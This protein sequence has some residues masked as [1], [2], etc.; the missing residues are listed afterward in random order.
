MIPRRR[1]GGGQSRAGWLAAVV[2]AG[3]VLTG[4]SDS[5]GD[6]DSSSE[7]SSG[8]PTGS[9][10]PTDSWRSEYDDEQLAAYEA[11]L[12]RWDEYETKSEP[13]WAAGKATP[14]AE[15]RRTV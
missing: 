5:D 3:S 4:C 2:I 10:S 14:A 13:I 7:S 15:T 6:A 8:S 11:A 9:A 1:S 12:G